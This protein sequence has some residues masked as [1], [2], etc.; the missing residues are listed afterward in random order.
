[1][2]GCKNIRSNFLRLSY[3]RVTYLRSK[4]FGSWRKC[5]NFVW[6]KLKHHFGAEIRVAE[7]WQVLKIWP[8]V[9]VVLLSFE[10]ECAAYIWCWHLA[11][12][13]SKPF[14]RMKHFEYYALLHHK[15]IKGI[16]KCQGGYSKILCLSSQFCLK[17][18][19]RSWKVI[20]NF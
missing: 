11:A 6:Y 8:R 3:L 4:K 15:I 13:R 9:F 18:R 14:P 2:Q 19:A 16:K 10:V 20:V 5:K 17:F 1:M 7:I 12:D